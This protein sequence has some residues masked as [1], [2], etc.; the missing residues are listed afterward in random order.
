MVL[1]MCLQMWAQFSCTLKMVLRAIS[2]NPRK[3]EI[4]HSVWFKSKQLQGCY[5]SLTN[6]IGTIVHIRYLARGQPY[7]RM[8]KHLVTELN[9]A[10][11]SGLI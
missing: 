11:G 4:G 8:N 1:N 10:V 3:T 6:A 2:S 9:I 7:P 5:S